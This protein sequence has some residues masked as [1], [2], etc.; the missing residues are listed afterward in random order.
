MTTLPNRLKQLRAESNL[1]QKDI[2]KKLNITASAYGFYEQGKRI[3][4]SNTLNSLAQIFNVSLDYLMGKS[5]I[6]T[7]NFKIDNAIQNDAELADFW[8][9][10]K[11]RESLQLLFKQTKDMD[12][13]DIN[14]VLRIIKAIEDE[15]DKHDSI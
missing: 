7:T 10:M 13:R 4:D 12:D 1:L 8:N 6:K 15:E 9:K 2:A 3:P 5:D 14:Q 11:E